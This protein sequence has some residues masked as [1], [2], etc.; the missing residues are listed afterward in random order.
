LFHGIISPMDDD[1]NK[2]NFSLALL[3][4]IVSLVLTIIAGIFWT[5]FFD[6]LLNL[7]TGLL[8]DIFYS[9]LYVSGLVGFFFGFLAVLN[10]LIPD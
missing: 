5:K 4:Y 1:D 10:R 6:F 2:S 9:I 3:R 7:S 8:Q